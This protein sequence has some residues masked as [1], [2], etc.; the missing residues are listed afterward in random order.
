MVGHDMLFS[1]RSDM[2]PD[3]AKEWV[4]TPHL[5]TVHWSLDFYGPPRPASSAG[6][7]SVCMGTCLRSN[8]KAQQVPVPLHQGATEYSRQSSSPCAG[9]M[10][11]RMTDRQPHEQCSLWG[12]AAP[13][14]MNTKPQLYLS[15]RATDRG[16][17]SG[18][19]IR[20]SAAIN[21]SIA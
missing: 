19:H 9:F 16:I 8:A 5:R 12:G 17:F 21:L 2:N 3:P 13:L 6:G 14:G 20:H 7:L 15:D 10:S 18:R 1:P 4:R 11:I